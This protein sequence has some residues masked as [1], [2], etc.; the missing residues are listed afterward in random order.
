MLPTGSGWSRDRHSAVK[1]WRGVAVGA[2]IALTVPVA[3]ILL[4]L[5]LDVGVLPPDQMH[6]PLFTM[7]MFSEV[8]LGPVGLAVAG[9]SA[10]VR[11]VVAWVLLLITAIPLLSAV[12][13]ISAL[14]FG[15]A[16]DSP[17]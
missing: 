13:V 10:G 4:S 11:G 6:A 8:L 14:M 2:F 17:F 9:W 16:T 12:W 5:L 7:I 1:S 15:G 3:F